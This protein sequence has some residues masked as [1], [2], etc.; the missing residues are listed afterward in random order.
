MKIKKLRIFEGRNIYSHKKAIYM[1]V[2]LQGF[3]DIPSKDIQGF[4][5]NLIYFIPELKNHKCCLNCNGGF[6]KRLEEGTYLAHI[7]EHSILAIQN[8]L[9]I[10]VSFG[11]ARE[12]KGE[13]YYIVFQYE[14]KNTAVEAAKQ[15]VLII[16]S[17]INKKIVNKDKI[18]EKLNLILNKELIGPSTKAILDEAKKRDIPVTEIENSGIYMLGYG[19]NGRLVESTIFENTSALSVDISCDKL[20]TKNILRSQYINTPEG[21]LVTS[22]IDLIK[23]FNEL[24]SK[25]VLKPR[26]GNQG[27]GVLIG[28]NKIEELI[29]GYKKILKEYKDIIIEK[30]FKGDDFRILVIN[31][32]ISAVSMRTPP[33]VIGD[34]IKTI[35]ELIEDINKHSN[36]GV[37]HEKPLTKICIDETLIFNIEK[38]GFTLDS[39]LK[40]KGK[41]LLRRNANLSTGGCGIDVTD[42]IC[43]YN[44]EIVLRA[45]KAIGL[46]ICG[47]DFICKDIS[48]PINKDEGIIEI[49][50]APGLRM[51]LFPGVGEKREVAKD[52]IDYM[53]NYNKASIPVV[54]ITGTNGKTTTTRLISHTISLLGKNVGMTSTGGI[55]IN[56]KCI[57]KGDTTGFNSARTVLLNK[58]ID[59]AIL[60]VA[61]GGLIRRG[62][63]YDLSDVGVITN[64]TE[65]HLGIDGI[66]T[67][68]DMAYVKALVGEAV[69]SNGCVVL[70]ADDKMCC[71]IR[72][73][74]KSEK[75]FFSKNPNN[76]VMV[77]NIKQGGCG[78]YLEDG[79]IYIETNDKKIKLIKIKEVGITFQGNL[80]YNAENAMAAVGALISL[81]IDY[82]TIK[83]GL[84]TFYCND[85]LNPGRFNIYHMDSAK[86]ILDYAHNI[87]GFKAIFKGVSNLK[88]NRKVGII[89][90]PGDR[91]DFTIIEAGRVCGEFFHEIIIKEDLDRRGR[92]KGEV[93]NLL[94]KGV[95]ESGVKKENIKLIL[96]E[97]DALNYT[98]SNIRTLDVVVVFFECYEPLKQIILDNIVKDTEI[99]IDI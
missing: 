66:N 95:I 44:K 61:R 74:I 1:E 18:Y 87:E 17:I 25:I 21:Y 92:K 23:R 15:A 5:E 76:S 24:G 70:N 40:D 45:V 46:N 42:N 62:L 67:L 55:F 20:L 38:C 48:K 72:N 91:D 56:G 89:G 35:R 28:I 34:G 33:F 96:D 39:I 29:E 82:V 22:K 84:K 86:I 13:L 14:Y 77:E 99:K 51:H 83:R 54:S 41:V 81:H 65:D 4:N 9:N 78:I 30:Q 68:E 93:A 27:K 79:Y 49:N 63:G 47:I 10:D 58:E 52:I 97:K 26:F 57:E 53:F 50:A 73:R 37:G 19:R 11:K 75:I 7:L 98:I 43:G 69:K 60:E 32:K 71:K 12:I 94:K 64:I 2:D 3:R 8:E 59:F 88:C 16:N 31:G 90:M 36:R 85:E 6:I 80:I